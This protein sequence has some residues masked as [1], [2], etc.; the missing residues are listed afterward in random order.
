MIC[1]SARIQLS[2]NFT[3]CS[4]PGSSPMNA[5]KRGGT[6]ARDRGLVSSNGDQG[7]PCD[8][9]VMAYVVSAMTLRPPTRAWAS[10]I[11]APISTRQRPTARLKDS[12]R[13]LSGN[14]PAPELV[15][16][17]ISARQ[18]CKG[19]RI[20]TI[21][22]GLILRYFQNH[23]S[24]PIRLG[25]K[26][27]VDAIHIVNLLRIYHQEK[28]CFSIPLIFAGITKCLIQNR[29]YI[30]FALNQHRPET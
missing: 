4:L 11:C 27:P 8:D 9:G 19:G 24:T 29:Y 5:G 18:T 26:Q 13:T 7:L 3:L 22:T 10:T 16:P 30:A 17:Q 28:F 12:S 21:G 15:R 1:V 6:F 25:A 20:S 23:Q 14:V 2:R